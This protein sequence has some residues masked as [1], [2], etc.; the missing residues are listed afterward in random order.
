MYGGNVKVA[1]SRK[2]KRKPMQKLSTCKVLLNN[3]PR[4]KRKPRRTKLLK[5]PVLE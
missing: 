5:Q 2:T 3:L 4:R 1:K